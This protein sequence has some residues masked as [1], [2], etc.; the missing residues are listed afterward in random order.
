M[1]GIKEVSPSAGAV[2]HLSNHK[3]KIDFQSLAAQ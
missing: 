3:L 2:A 1:E